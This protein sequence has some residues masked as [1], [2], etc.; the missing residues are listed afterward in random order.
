MGSTRRPKKVRGALDWSGGGRV[1]LREVQGTLGLT[2]PQA[3]A[4]LALEKSTGVAREGSEHPARLWEKSQGLLD[5]E[6]QLW[7]SCI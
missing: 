5:H 4:H 1:T 3:N 2:P 7:E 6:P